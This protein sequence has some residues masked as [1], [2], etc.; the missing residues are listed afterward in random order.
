[1]NEDEDEDVSDV[2]AGSVCAIMDGSSFV[3]LHRG[4]LTALA[5]PVLHYLGSYAASSLQRS[6]LQESSTLLDAIQLFATEKVPMVFIA[7]AKRRPLGK[8]T[9]AQLFTIIDK[10]QVG[11]E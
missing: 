7:D 8:L 3:G 9:V 10:F 4:D 2:I 6:N 1:M 5:E 11:V